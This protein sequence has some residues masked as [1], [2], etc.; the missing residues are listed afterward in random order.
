MKRWLFNIAAGVSVVVFVVVMVGW[1]FSYLFYW[2]VKYPLWPGVDETT[3]GAFALRGTLVIKVSDHLR[4]YPWF[5]KRAINSQLKTPFISWIEPMTWSRLPSRSRYW[6]RWGFGYR[7]DAP[8]R[9]EIQ[10]N[11]P[12]W[13]LATITGDDHWRPPDALAHPLASPPC[14]ARACM[15]K[16]RVRFT[17]DAG[18]GADTGVPG[19]RVAQPAEKNQNSL[20]V[21][22]GHYLPTRHPLGARKPSGQSLLMSG[23][24]CR[25]LEA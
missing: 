11:G 23:R 6:S 5:E 20:A 13:S 10:V 24:T 2:Q 8:P 9:S 7:I 17:G 14:P 18:G 19:V 22:L 21:G 25:R 16:V 12:F 1:S 3:V 15:R 4:P